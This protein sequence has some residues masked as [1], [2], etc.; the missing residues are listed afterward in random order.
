MEKFWMCIKSTL[1]IVLIYCLSSC[2]QVPVQP[3]IVTKIDTVTNVKYDT[4]YVMKHDTVESDNDFQIGYV[5]DL[6]TKLI[7]FNLD[8]LISENNGKHLVTLKQDFTLDCNNLFDDNGILDTTLQRRD[9]VIAKTIVRVISKDTLMNVNTNNEIIIHQVDTVTVYKTIEKEASSPLSDLKAI[10]F[11][12]PVILL[13][14][15][16]FYMGYKLLNKR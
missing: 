16:L 8:T 4:V 11:I 12:I 3:T 7:R 6:K 13:L 5:A 15:F 1:I 9:F 2:K 14:A 10:F